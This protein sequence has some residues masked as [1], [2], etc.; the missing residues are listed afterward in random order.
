VLIISFGGNALS[1]THLDGV[2]WAISLVLGAISLPVAV[3]IRLIPNSLI[4][5][6]FHMDT[7]HRR[8]SRIEL[9]NGDDFVHDGL[10]ESMRASFKIRRNSQLSL[11]RFRKLREIFSTIRE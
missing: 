1:A 8:T 10:L 5:G 2:Q 3:I 4:R 9:P 11:I 7:D 6:L